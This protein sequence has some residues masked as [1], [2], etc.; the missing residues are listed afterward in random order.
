MRFYKVSEKR[1]YGKQVRLF[2]M[3]PLL[4][5]CLLAAGCGSKQEASL[6]VEIIMI[7]NN[8]CESCDEEGRLSALLQENLPGE[9]D[10]QYELKI[11]YAYH[12]EGAEL[13]DR[14]AAYFGFDESEIFFPLVIVGDRFLSGEEQVE[15]QL[16]QCLEEA[17]RNGVAGAMEGEPA[18]APADTVSAEREETV[19][20]AGADVIHL[21]YFETEICAKC[22]KA[23]E[24]LEALPDT[25]NIEGREYPVV[26]TKLSVAEGN[27]ASIFGALAK[28]AGVSSRKQ[29]VP[30]L[31]L[32]EKYLSGADEITAQVFQ[33]V[34]EGAGL[35]A[36]YRAGS[37]SQNAA[38]GAESSLA[39]DYREQ[40]FVNIGMARGAWYPL[41]LLRT[42]GVGFLNGFNPCALSLVLLFFSLIGTMQRNFL[43]NGLTFLAGKLTAYILLGL[44]VS[45]AL[46]AIP[47]EAFAWVR[48][49][50]TLFLVVLC[51]VLACGNFLDC[52]HAW[53]GEYG[54]IRVQ[55]P[56]SLRSRNDRL[57]KRIAEFGDSRWFPVLIFGGSM[58]I[59]LGEFFCTGQIYLASILQWV[60]QEEGGV[61]LTAFVLYSAALCLPSLIILLLIKKGKSVLSLANKS[62]KGM[63]WIKLCNGILF[64]IFLVWALLF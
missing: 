21:L 47:F 10:F 45:A 64:V 53:K 31:F 37:P 6:P 13:V 26:I 60:K 7:H 4:L 2:W 34:E 28:E 12:E 44:A 33:L 9:E 61:P 36:V 56:G 27:N 11:L 23:K 54:K 58:A 59:A 38:A 18:H 40:P 29:Q 14:A 41:F 55:L 30:F 48:R 24:A 32:G 8:P 50:L 49:A 25:V 1:G 19:I 46:S 3:C 62:L 22:E 51:L 20:D 15:E 17:G 35:G 43:R 39:E 42:V 16:A 63:P 5:L 57:V 52:Y